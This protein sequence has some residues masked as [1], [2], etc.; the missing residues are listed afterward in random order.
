MAFMG[1]VGSHTHDA[2]LQAI[3]EAVKVRLIH[4]VRLQQRL[5]QVTG[6]PD[7][8]YP[9]SQSLEFFTI[10]PQYKN[11]NLANFVLTMPFKI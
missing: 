4:T 6:C 10:Y 5:T 2:R 9:V 11:A 3:E 7:L 1:C 8:T